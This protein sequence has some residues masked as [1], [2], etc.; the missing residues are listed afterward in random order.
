MHD[1]PE[2]ARHVLQRAIGIVQAQS[3]HEQQQVDALN[4]LLSGILT[5]KA[6]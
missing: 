3:G 2:A 5:Q 4:E 1:A 6:A